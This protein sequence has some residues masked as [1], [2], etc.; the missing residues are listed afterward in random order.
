MTLFITAGG[1]DHKKNDK[2]MRRHGDRENIKDDWKMRRWGDRESLNFKR[3]NLG[4]VDHNHHFLEHFIL[5][6][7]EGIGD[8]P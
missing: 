5:V 8:R 7:G 2:E 4:D 3:R 6:T 1:S